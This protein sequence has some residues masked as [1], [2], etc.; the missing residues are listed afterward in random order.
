MRAKELTTAALL[1]ALETGNFYA[2]TGVVLGDVKFDSASRTL[3]LEIVPTPGATYTTHFIGTR[4]P[5]GAQS[6]TY[7]P[8]AEEVGVTL[9]TVEG[10]KPTY[11]MNGNELYVRAVVMSSLAPAVPAYK[12][13]FQQAWTQP[14]GWTKR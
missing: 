5:A 4:L 2:S 10:L 1:A 8:K 14:V 3:S 9:A 13:Q 11:Q 6:A 7:T 12:P